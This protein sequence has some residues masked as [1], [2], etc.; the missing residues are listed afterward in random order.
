MPRTFLKD[1]RPG[2]Y[3][4][5]IYLFSNKQLST[6]KNG[7][8][9]VKA[10][11]GDRSCTLNAR[12]W[13]VSQER[14]DNLP[15]G[16]FVRIHAKIE[17]YQENLQLVIDE[18]F[19]AKAGTYDIADLVPHTT[20]NIEQMFTS[21]TVRLATIKNRHLAGIVEAY[22]ADAPLMNDFKRAPAA[23]SF[24]HAFLGGLLEHTLNAVEVAEVV[25]PFYPGLNRD[26]VVAGIFLHDIAKTWE[27]TFG[28]A[29]AYSDGGQL[30][31]H[32][33]KSVMWVE[34]K[35]RE[36]EARLG[37][38]IPEPLVEVLQHIILSH[39]DRPEF[40]S[41]KVPATPEAIVV[42]TLENMDAKLQMALAA[43]RGENAVGGNWTDWMK[44]FN[45]KLF[46]PDVAPADDTPTSQ[47]ASTETRSDVSPAG[48]EAAGAEA[49]GVEAAV[50]EK[51]IAKAGGAADSAPADRVAGSLPRLSN[52][53]FE[54]APSRQK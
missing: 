52:P 39:H 31:G 50:A 2:D 4:E 15:D 6:A 44:A 28:T 54:T 41:P 26:V 53:L 3:V 10:N 32:I 42:H 48:V 14:F 49:A 5:E 17:N 16:A 19:P 12:W 9:F 35:R 24:H 23:Q 18:M 1:A 33:V 30:I 43:C 13:N 8:P 22:L 34:D 7:K 29:F 25:C 37:E 47:A 45:G 46:R 51:T 40:G 38:S 27:L 21:L 36:A 20:K 11:V